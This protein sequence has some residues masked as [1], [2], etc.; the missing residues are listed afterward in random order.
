MGGVLGPLAAGLLIAEVSCTGIWIMAAIAVFT[1]AAVN[2]PE[3][4]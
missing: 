1:G 2:C 3:G 4:E